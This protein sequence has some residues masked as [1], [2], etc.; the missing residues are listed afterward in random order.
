MKTI[1]DSQKNDLLGEIKKL[2]SEVIQGKEYPSTIRYPEQLKALV[3]EGVKLGL[4]GKEIC[5]VTNIS[6]TT[7]NRWLISS[8]KEQP[9]IRKLK[10]VANKPLEQTLPLRDSTISIQLPSGVLI[11]FTDAKILNNE[12]LFVLSSLERRSNHVVG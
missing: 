8:K 6:I 10:V 1:N 9:K 2:S 4:K 7:I 5:L 3:R 12:F 11:K